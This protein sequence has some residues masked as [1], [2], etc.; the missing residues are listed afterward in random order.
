MLEPSLNNKKTDG[1]KVG[2]NSIGVSLQIYMIIQ[3]NLDESLHTNS[4][5]P[6][7]EEEDD[8]PEVQEDAA[9]AYDPEV[10]DDAAQVHSPEVQ[11]NPEV[12][13]STAKNMT[14][15]HLEGPGPVP[16]NADHRVPYA[17]DLPE[18]SPPLELPGAEL[19]G[20]PRPSVSPV[21]RPTGFHMRL[22]PRT[23]RKVRFHVQP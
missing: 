1:M 17:P 2:Q 23:K 13:D 18:I 21:S 5:L 4:D 15:S 19:E 6:S 11:D 20:A 3:P 16:P 22:R 12:Q 7:S 9:L 14:E 10:Q 8:A